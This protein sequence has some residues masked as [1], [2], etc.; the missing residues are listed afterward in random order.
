MRIVAPT[1][2]VLLLLAASV[3]AAAPTLAVSIQVSPATIVLKAPLQWLTI[4]ADIACSAV[5]R[6]TVAINGLDADAVFADNC[7]NLVAKVHFERIRPLLSTPSAQIV[8]TGVTNDGVAFSGSAT[9]PV[10]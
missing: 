6:S 8:L 5:D 10:K 9:V 7:G 1:L 3:H 2:C 4:H